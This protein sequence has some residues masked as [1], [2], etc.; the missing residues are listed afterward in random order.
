MTLWWHV[1]V[2]HELEPVLILQVSPLCRDEDCFSSGPLHIPSN[3]W[4]HPAS[5]R[6]RPY[7]SLFLPTLFS[8]CGILSSCL[9]QVR[10]IS[11]W[12]FSDLLFSR[13]LCTLKIYWGP[14]FPMV[15]WLRV[16]LPMQGTWV[17][18]L[19][20]EL[21]SHMLQGK[22]ETHNWDPAQPNKNNKYFLKLLRSQRT[23]MWAI[24]INI[25]HISNWN[26]F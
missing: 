11:F 25:Y 23:F 4:K 18:A 6:W 12:W 3:I 19:I 7:R 26:K 9:L 14:N 22:P 13:F 10:S 17:Q 20:G 21:Q 1:L 24:L 2:L 16:H 5:I 15:Q 8:L